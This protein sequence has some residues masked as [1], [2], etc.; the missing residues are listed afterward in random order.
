MLCDEIVSVCVC[1]FGFVAS[2]C[3]VLLG[4]LVSRLGC[5]LARHCPRPHASLSRLRCP[6]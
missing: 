4:A 1:D 2:F 6:L 5:E 3:D